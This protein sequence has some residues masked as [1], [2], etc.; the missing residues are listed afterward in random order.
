MGRNKLELV[1]NVAFYIITIIGFC[2]L[3]L[4]MTGVIG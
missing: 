3:T 4:V 1:I 2:V